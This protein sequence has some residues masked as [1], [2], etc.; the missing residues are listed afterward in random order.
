MITT[1]ELM[2]GDWVLYKGHPVQV[3]EIS[4]PS[5]KVS[6]ATAHMAAPAVSV[7]DIE[8][9]PLTAEILRDSG[10]GKTQLMGEQ[11][12]FTYQVG[13][14]LSLLAI[15]DADFSF[16]IGESARKI[17]YVHQ[18]QHIIRW[19]GFDSYKRII[20]KPQNS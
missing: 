6:L 18:L 16:Q 17:L 12:H 8:P 19:C 13:P 2:T 14:S 3:E 20:V 1:E 10:I 15:Y 5:Q 9:V 7:N 11:R 4:R